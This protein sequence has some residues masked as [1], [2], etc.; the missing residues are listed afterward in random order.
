MQIMTTVVPYNSFYYQCADIVIAGDGEPTEPT[1]TD[2]GCATGSG[3]GLGAGI[4]ALG[5]VLR[6]RRR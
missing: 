6:R 5:L 3:T 4:A 1:D 2:G